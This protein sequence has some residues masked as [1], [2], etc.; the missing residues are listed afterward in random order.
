[1]KK[2]LLSSVYLLLYYICACVVLTCALAVLYMIYALCSGLVAGQVLSFDLH[3]FIAGVLYFAPVVLVFGPLLMVFFLIRHPV[4]SIIPLIV[5]CLLSLS[6]WFF[7]ISQLVRMNISFE[8]KTAGERKFTKPSAGYFRRMGDAVFYYSSVGEEDNLVSGIGIDTA[9]T[10]RRVYTFSSMNFS[11]E[12]SR[13]GDSLILDTLEMP[14]ALSLVVS[15]GSRLR[16]LFTKRAV[17]SFFNWLCFASVGLA[18]LAVYGLKNV[19]SWRLVNVLLAM[20]MT[21][22]IIGFNVAGYTNPA[23]AQAENSFITSMKF[24]PFLKKLAAV[25]PLVIF[26]NILACVILAVVGLIVG[27]RRH[28]AAQDSVVEEEF[29]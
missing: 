13:M 15:H 14:P 25:H 18:L 3:F 17:G 1:M 27:G 21:G 16:N 28:F 7:T 10:S 22:A 4:S 2:G 6:A 24:L 9:A 23:F 8:K 11:P 26:G 29:V 12:N 20:V 19:S 5:Y